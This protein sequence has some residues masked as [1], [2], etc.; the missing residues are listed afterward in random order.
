M[1]WIL[2]YFICLISFLAL[3]GLFIGGF[4][5]KAYRK[6][7]GDI[8]NKKPKVVPGVILY[9]LYTISILVLAV[10]PLN[11]YYHHVLSGSDFWKIIL[12]GGGLGFTAYLIYS[13]TA[14]CLV[15]GW[16]TKIAVIDTIWGTVIT[17]SVTFIG[18]IVIH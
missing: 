6:E 17:A 16:K 10:L 2:D 3:D 15:K 13:L 5:S 9:S 12:W 14:L 7:L 11:R 18:Y 8:L 1:N 4:A